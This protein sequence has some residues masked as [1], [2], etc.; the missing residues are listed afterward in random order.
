MPELRDAMKNYYSLGLLPATQQCYRAGLKQYTAFCLQ[1]HLPI[2]PASEHTLLLFV[3][4]LALK[5]LPLRC[6]WQQSAVF[7]STQETMLYLT[8]S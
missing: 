8:S 4:H 5:K 3:T 6:I 7:M 2:V 1:A